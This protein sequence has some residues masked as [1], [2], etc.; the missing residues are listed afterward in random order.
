MS[1]AT[2]VRVA[3]NSPKE[4]PFPENSGLDIPAGMMAE[5]DVEVVRLEQRSTKQKPCVSEEAQAERETDGQY[6]L[7]VLYSMSLNYCMCAVTVCS[8]LYSTGGKLY[9]STAVQ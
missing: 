1:H 8:V 3:L 4:T 5:F 6:S 9:C 7:E 2:G